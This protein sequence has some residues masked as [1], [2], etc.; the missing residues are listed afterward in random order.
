MFVFAKNVRLRGPQHAVAHMPPQ[1]T[2]TSRNLSRRLAKPA[3]NNG[4][5]QRAALRALWALQTASTSQI[6]RWTRALKRYRGERV[7]QNDA[8][9]ARRVLDRYAVRVGR[10]KTIG[11]P[12]LWRIRPEYD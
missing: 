6:L 8:R 3:L 1:I 5:V 2:R 12:V 7:G 11:R 9:A 10:A 4:R